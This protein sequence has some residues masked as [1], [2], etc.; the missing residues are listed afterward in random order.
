MTPAEHECF[1][2][3]TAAVGEEF[4]IFAQVHLATIVDH[5]IPGQDWRAALS[6]IDRKSVDFV[7]CDKNSL[8]TKLAIELDDRTHEQSDRVERDGIV[9]GILEQAGVPLLRLGNNGS[10]DP[11]D[12]RARIHSALQ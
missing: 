11:V 4:Q 7:L 5:K 12:L 6:H 1:K 3:L 2:A 9:E 10:L 8:A